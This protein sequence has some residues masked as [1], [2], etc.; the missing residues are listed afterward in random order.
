MVCEASATSQEMTYK[1]P[2]QPSKGLPCKDKIVKWILYM[3]LKTGTL[4]TSRLQNTV[5]QILFEE[6]IVT[7]LVKAD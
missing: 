5:Y 1:R 3:I 6:A 7:S 2:V 4:N